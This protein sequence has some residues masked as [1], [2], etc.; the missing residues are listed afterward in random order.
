MSGY[1]VTYKKYFSCKSY[2]ISKYQLV[3]HGTTDVHFIQ[4]YTQNGLMSLA[5]LLC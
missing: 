2:L 1:P 5:C 4:M 3:L